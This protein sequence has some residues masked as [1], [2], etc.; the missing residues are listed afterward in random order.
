MRIRIKSLI[1]SF[2]NKGSKH[3]DTP[4]DKQRVRLINFFILLLLTLLLPIG[5]IQK[6]SNGN[7]L[8]VALISMFYLLSLLIMYL[9]QRGKNQIAALICI[10][11]PMAITFFVVF[12]ID[13]QTAAPYLNLYVGLGAFYLIRNPLLKNLLATMSFLS[14][15]ITNY[16]QLRYLP[17]VKEEYFLVILML[18]LIYIMVK[19][20]VYE[21]NCSRNQITKKNKKLLELNREKDGILGIVAHDLHTP[22]NNIKS[23]FY[24]M[25]MGEIT[26][27]EHQ[28]LI[29]RINDSVDQANHLISDLLDINNFQQDTFK[30]NAV[31]INLRDFLQRINDNYKQLAIN[32]QQLLKCTTEVESDIITDELMLSRIIENLLSNAIKFSPFSTSINVKIKQKGEKFIISIKDEGPGFTVEDKTKIFGKFQKLSARPTNSENSTGLG[33]SII[34]SLVDKLK[35]TIELFSENGQGSEFVLTFRSLTTLFKDEKN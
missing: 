22:F 34:K 6:A 29:D 17:F 26:K 20:F 12:N 1:L 8:I 13:H 25:G 35:G 27:S 3:Y 15:A 19:F 5:G 24:L 21:L 11:P 16:Y 7:Y 4:E 9:N 33:L 31:R 2:I 18:I 14:F 32:K 30:I 28:E 23:L 10:I